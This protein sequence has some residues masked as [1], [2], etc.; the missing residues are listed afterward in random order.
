MTSGVD[1]G[2]EG[3]RL[4]TLRLPSVLVLYSLPLIKEIKRR[5]YSGKLTAEPA[6]VDGRWVIKVVYEG[7]EP[8]TD[9]QTLKFDRVPGPKICVSGTSAASLP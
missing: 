7:D 3:G 1:G 4:S 9:I 5:G 8:V 6:L 2:S